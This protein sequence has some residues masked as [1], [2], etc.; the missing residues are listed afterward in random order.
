MNET[1]PDCPCC[2]SSGSNRRHISGN[3]WECT[4][5]ACRFELNERGDVVGWL[6]G[7]GKRI[8]RGQACQPDES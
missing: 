4:V 2:D 7:N 6:S 8:R 5:C 1:N 3:H